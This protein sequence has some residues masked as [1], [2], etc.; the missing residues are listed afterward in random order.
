M[1]PSLTL[2]IPTCAPTSHRKYSFLPCIHC[3]PTAWNGG[4]NIG[5][6]H[7]INIHWASTGCQVLYK[8]DSSR[9]NNT[10][11]L[12]SNYFLIWD[13]VFNIMWL[14]RIQACSRHSEERTDSTWRRRSLS[15]ALK[16]SYQDGKGSP[17]S[18]KSQGTTWRH[19]S[20]VCLRGTTSSW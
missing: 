12:P 5:M 19:E 1:K 8:I 2:L 15:W 10:W 6:N 4:E 18:R 11:F 20:M 9:T 7:S 14:V 13:I 3:V 16:I 17:G